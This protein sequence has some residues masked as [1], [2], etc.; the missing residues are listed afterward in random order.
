MN[1][2]WTIGESELGL[3]L[4][5]FPGNLHLKNKTSKHTHDVRCKVCIAQWMHGP[6]T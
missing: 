1:A 5:N 4:A 3:Y 2:N 6:V